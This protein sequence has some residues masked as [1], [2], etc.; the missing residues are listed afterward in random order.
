[1]STSYL[2]LQMI[3]LIAIYES[4]INCVEQSDAD[5]M[6]IRASTLEFLHLHCSG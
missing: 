5:S 2:G 6:M 3:L 1:M 4:R